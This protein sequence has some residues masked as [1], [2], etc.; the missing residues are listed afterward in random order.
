MGHDLNHNTLKQHPYDYISSVVLDWQGD[1]GETLWKH[2]RHHHY[3]YRHASLGAAAVHL[4]LS[5]ASLCEQPTAENW[6]TITLVLM[7]HLCKRGYLLL[8]GLDLDWKLFRDSAFSHKTGS[9]IWMSQ[10]QFQYCIVT[11]LVNS[12]CC[13]IYIDSC[14]VTSHFF[15]AW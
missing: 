1:T 6:R 2:T 14:S 3:V 5:D 12:P 8:I 15:F 9:W 7:R 11:A 4:Y 13:R 10:F